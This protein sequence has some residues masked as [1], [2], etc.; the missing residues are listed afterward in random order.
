MQGYLFGKP[1]PTDEFALSLDQSR[2]ML[3][4]ILPIEESR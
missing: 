3:T 2:A 4:P 1:V